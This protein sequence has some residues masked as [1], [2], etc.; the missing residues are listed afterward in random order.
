[1]TKNW[2]IFVRR[3]KRPLAG[4]M[5]LALLGSVTV[6][7]AQ[8]DEDRQIADSMAGDASRRARR[9]L[10]QP[11]AHQRP[12]TRPQGLDGT[13][14]V[15]QTIAIYR[16]VTGIDPLTLDPASRHGR[17]LGDEMAAIKEGHG[18]QPVF[19]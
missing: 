19:H 18:R 4:A 7:A 16:N 11:A 14:V 1:M 13:S 2:L 9:D 3:R 5:M 12:I 6:M 17:L 10:K 8:P 15:A